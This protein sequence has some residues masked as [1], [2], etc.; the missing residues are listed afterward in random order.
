MENAISEQDIIEC[1]SQERDRAESALSDTYKAVLTK[2]DRLT[3][4]GEPGATDAK[5]QLVTAQNE[6]IEFREADCDVVFLLNVGGSVRIPATLKCLADH[7]LQRNS[8]LQKIF[9]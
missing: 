2:L 7:A 3:S 9:N 8:E 5:E 6:W 1:A 4:E